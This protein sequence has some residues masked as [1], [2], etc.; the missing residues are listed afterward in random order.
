MSAALS[1]STQND[2][3]FTQ[4]RRSFVMPLDFMFEASKFGRS[5]H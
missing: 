1:H 5:P 4:D 3:T 2:R